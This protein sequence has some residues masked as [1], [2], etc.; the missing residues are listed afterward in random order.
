MKKIKSIAKPATGTIYEKKSEF[1]A[2]IAPLTS[3]DAAIDFVN[4]IRSKYSNARHNVYAYVI[5]KD[6]IS[7][8]SDDGEPQGT[9]GLPIINLL[10]KE[11]FFDIAVV[12]TRYFGGVLLG[13]GGLARAYANA[14]KVA[15]ENSNIVFFKELFQYTLD[16]NYS[17]LSKFQVMEDLGLLCIDSIKYESNV[18]VMFSVEKHKSEKVI[19]EITKIT[20]GRSCPVLQRE[21]S[22]YQ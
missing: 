2:N 19:G 7:R 12:V 5:K 9:G 11:S 20:C 3:E 6:N 15:L 8:Y 4:A 21:Y 1:I 10:R 16:L 17:E 13:V 14:A 22:A 18:L